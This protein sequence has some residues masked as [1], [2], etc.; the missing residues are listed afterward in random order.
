MK[1][2]QNLTS[3]ALIS[4]SQNPVFAT[5]TAAEQ[6]VESTYSTTF[7]IASCPAYSSTIGQ[8][9][10]QDCLEEENEITDTVQSSTRVAEMAVEKEGK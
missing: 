9:T 8:P 4:R 10:P 7:D 1:H 2:I 6:G 3:H 5:N